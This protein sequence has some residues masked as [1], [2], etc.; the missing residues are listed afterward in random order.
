VTQSSA[1]RISKWALTGSSFVLAVN[2]SSKIPQ[3]LLCSALIISLFYFRALF[4]TTLPCKK[5][6]ITIS[7]ISGE[8]MEKI[9]S[10]AYTRDCTI[11]ED[12]ILELFAA[13]DF[14]AMSGLQ[15]RCIKFMKD[16]LNLNNCIERMIYAR[17]AGRGRSFQREIVYNNLVFR[18]RYNQELIEATRK[19]VLKNFPAI[20]ESNE[21]LM[22][23][24]IDD[25][26]ELISDEMLNVKDEQPVWECV[27]RW[28]DYDPE[29]RSQYLVRLMRGIRLGLIDTKV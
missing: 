11:E 29:K 16:T 22:R 13:T 14:L 21:D 17:Y 18:D 15:K 20:F 26:Y 12:T 4:T 1:R 23:L 3:F 7:G 19:Y 5:D 6:Q 2:I 10:W 24:N 28:I 9:M 25:F 27:V 8:I